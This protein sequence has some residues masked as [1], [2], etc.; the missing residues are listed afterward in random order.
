[1][2]LLLSVAVGAVWPRMMSKT[3]VITLITVLIG[4]IPLALVYQ[5]FLPRRP[6]GSAR[7]FNAFM[8]IFEP[9]A[10][11]GEEWKKAN[12]SN[13]QTASRIDQLFEDR[14]VRAQL[15]RAYACRHFHLTSVFV[16]VAV[17]MAGLATWSTVIAD[18]DIRTLG[19]LMIFPGVVLGLSAFLLILDPLDRAKVKAV[20]PKKSDAN[21]SPVHEPF[22]GKNSPAHDA[23][24]GKN[25]SRGHNNGNDIPNQSVHVSS[26]ASRL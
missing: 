13:P 21:G 19:R 6:R 12:P 4:W 26:R 17:A 11:M 3:V 25:V 22:N 9:T 14:R 20:Q 2:G 23:M 1:L 15:I 24:N 10:A 16:S 5:K 8:D 18:A 7:E